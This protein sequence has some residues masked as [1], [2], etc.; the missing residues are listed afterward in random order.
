MEFRASAVPFPEAGDT[1]SGTVAGRFQIADRLGHGGMGEVYRAEDTKLKRPVAL[2]RLGPALR[3]DSTYRRRFQEEA[4]RAS[5][6]TDAHVA[7]VY[8]VLEEQNEL[9]LVMEYVEGQ[10]LRQRL[11]S[12]VTLEEFFD[13]ATQCAEALMAAHSR[14]IV[15]CDIKPENIMLTPAGQVKI[16]DFGVAKHLPRS[17]Q[18]STVDRAGSFGGTPAY[19]APE[20]LLEKIP[21]GRADIFS[22]GIVLYEALTGLHPFLSNSFVATSERILHETPAPIHI[23]NAQVPEALEAVVNKALA[24]DPGQRYQDAGSL[25]QDLRLVQ[26]GLTP[27]KLRPLL[28]LHKA[29]NSRRWIWAAVAAAFMVAAAIVIAYQRAGTAPLLA[30]RGWVLITDFDS[31][32]EDP[33]PDAGVREGLTIALQQSR[34]VNVFP[35]T[36]VYD[37]LQRM[38]RTDVTRIDE[39]LGREICQREN[40]QVLLTGSI[41][42]MGQVFQITVRATDPV[43]GNLLFAEKERFENKEQFF[44]KAD[45]LSRHVRKDLGESRIGIEKTSKPLAKVT[46]RSLEALQLYSR[47]TDAIAQ[48]DTDQV[49]VLL[50]S[51][52]HFDPDFAMAHMRL[53][54]YY[55]WVLGKNERALDELTEAYRLREAVTDREQRRIEADYF[56]IQERYEEA[57]QSLAVLVGLYPD[58]VEGHEELAGA[59]YNVGQLDRAIA[60]E[61]E[62][63]RLNPFSL[64]AYRNLVLYLARSNASEEAITTFQAAQQRGVVSPQLHRGLG[65]AYLGQGN[66]EQARQQ[67]TELGKGTETD[68]ELRDLYLA[69]ADLYQGKLEAARS[70]LAKRV[71]AAPAEV[72]GLQLVRRYFLGRIYLLQNKPREALSQADFMLATPASNLQTS[73]LLRAGILYTRAG[74][75]SKANEVLRRLDGARKSI[76]SSWNKSCYDNLEG[77]IRLSEKV[78]GQAETSFLASASEYP[79][80]FSHIGLARAYAAQGKAELA[81]QEWETVLRAKGEML[82][83]SFVPDL[84]AAHLGLARACAY[85]D[86]QRAGAQYN[87]FLQLWQNADDLP[88]LREAHREAQDLAKI[89]GS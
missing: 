86:R 49:P 78:D 16:L 20:V 11:R 28:P 47:A 14:R 62:V 71:A 7:A 32:G 23:F 53:G 25:L 17:D 30:E 80:S 77:E 12:P 5:L 36:R 81:G 34:Y 58:D 67:F 46:T 48:G 63:L 75:L 74:S 85:F 38:K 3:A 31:R 24:K 76:P 19:M 61:R 2:K 41:E 56:N 13:I 42:H 29:R 43:H 8:D 87:E 70:R 57:A 54:D 37:V 51:A 60:E 45:E 26:A 65:L 35:R 50:Q 82:Q 52:L 18:S 59:Y 55:E 79:D 64:P 6:F 10:N 44:E 4:Q 66:V 83:D 69:V 72:G 22:L 15:H 33:I 89:K 27:T 9:F 84:I 39:N 88:M 73:D 1:L 21:D 40:L 68:Q